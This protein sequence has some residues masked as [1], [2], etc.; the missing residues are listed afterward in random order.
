MNYA[1]VLRKIITESA[2]G[3]WELEEA[4]LLFKPHPNKWSKQEIL[5]HLIDS[6]YNNHQRF[7]RTEAQGNLVFHGYDQENWVIKN[8]YQEREK[9]D[10]IE[11]Y[12]IVNLHLSAM[13]AQLSSNVLNNLTLDHNY[14][15]I[16]MER[17]AANEP[18]N[19]AYLVHDY[20]FHI[21]HHLKQL[22][23]AYERIIPSQL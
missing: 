5:G 21:E 4:D 20:L 8:A 14:H 17:I 13:I 3:L 16:C 19:L 10:V 9:R 6:A 22:L 7:L 11:T 23:P 18:T 15:Q 12:I 2:S 1:T